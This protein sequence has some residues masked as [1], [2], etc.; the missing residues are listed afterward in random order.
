VSTEHGEKSTGEGN[1][2]HTEELD[3]TSK[4]LNAFDWKFGSELANRGRVR[5]CS[6]R[7]TGKVRRAY[8]GSY[9]ILGK[10]RHA[11]FG[12]SLIAGNV[13]RDLLILISIYHFSR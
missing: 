5:L 10:G 2:A 13:R 9:L 6:S 1:W 4:N 8:F 3:Q 11:Y 7:F 12:T